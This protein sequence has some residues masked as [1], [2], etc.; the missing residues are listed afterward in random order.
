MYQKRKGYYCSLAIVTIIPS[1][2]TGEDFAHF[3]TTLAYGGL[4]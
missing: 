1:P 3:G 2:K 4:P